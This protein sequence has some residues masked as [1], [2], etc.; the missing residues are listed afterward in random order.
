MALSE[1][2]ATAGLV[3]GVTVVAGALALRQWHERRHRETELSDDDARHFARQD[4]RRAVVSVVLLLLALSIAFGSRIEPRPA[5]RP[6]PLFLA[7]WLAIFGL[8]FVLVWLALLDGI[9]TWLYA[10]RHG[11]AIARERIEFLRGERRRRSYRGNGRTEP[12]GSIDGP[13]TG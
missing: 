9:A 2:V 1:G 3:I 12:P 5:G 4:F 8:I 7:V 11:R 6:S 10:R 13:P